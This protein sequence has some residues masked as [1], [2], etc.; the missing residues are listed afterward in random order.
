MDVVYPGCSHPGLTNGGNH[1]N[2]FTVRG[3]HHK[4]GARGTFK[5]LRVKAGEVADL[6]LGGELSLC[7]AVPGLGVE[8]ED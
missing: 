4:P 3:Y 7:C 6:C 1:R 8:I 2:R 5:E